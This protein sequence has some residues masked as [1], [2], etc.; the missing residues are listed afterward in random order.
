MY[1]SKMK[2]ERLVQ[3]ANQAKTNAQK[4]RVG[5]ALFKLM[6]DIEC[7]PAKFLYKKNKD[8][9]QI[10]EG[11]NTLGEGAFGAVFYGCLDNECRTRVAI[12]FSKKSL[13]SEYV[14]GKKL[15][16]LGVAP[17]MYR[18]G[19]CPS[20]KMEFIYYEYASHGSL[21]DY[22]DKYKNFLKA[23]DYKAIVYQVYSLLRKVYKKYP[24]YKHYDLHAGNVLVNKERGKMRVLLTDF[25]LSEMK[26]VRS[27]LLKKAWRRDQAPDALVFTYYLGKALKRIPPT[28]V[29]FFQYVGESEYFAKDTSMKVIADFTRHPF[30]KG[31]HK[32]VLRV[33]PAPVI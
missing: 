24:S 27:P 20:K 23:S 7:N 2:L 14:I 33:P 30:M 32:S 19:Y 10:T 18:Y 12:K 29:S 31:A 9:L 21:D 26:G 22:V 28:A 4:N 1:C 13:K 17:R 16:E 11:V 15:A 6:D 8:T 5:N 3:I 25:G